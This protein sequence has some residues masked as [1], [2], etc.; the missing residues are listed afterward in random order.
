MT[1]SLPQSQDHMDCGFL[2]FGAVDLMDIAVEFCRK[3]MKVGLR[4]SGSGKRCP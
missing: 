1:N 3:K 2:H 4:G